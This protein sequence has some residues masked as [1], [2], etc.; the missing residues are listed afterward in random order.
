MIRASSTCPI[1]RRILLTTFARL[2]SETNTPGQTRSINSVFDNTRGRCS[3]SNFNSSNAFGGRWVTRP[4]RTSCRVSMS[5]VQSANRIFT[6][7]PGSGRADS[8]RP[9][10]KIHEKGTKRSRPARAGDRY[11]RPVVDEF[12]RSERKGAVMRQFKRIVFVA[13]AIAALTIGSPASARSA[14]HV[15]HPGQSIQAAV[16]AASPGDTVRV[17]PASTTRA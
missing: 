9:P 13:V 2:A 3:T 16:D 11:S 1:A 15:V 7:S 14:T 10:R 4:L 6:A 17:W 12:D 5:S 8:S